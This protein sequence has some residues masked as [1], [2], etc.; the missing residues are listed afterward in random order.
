MAT[1]DP[2]DY[3]AATN[4]V[5]ASSLAEVVA[6]GVALLDERSPDWWRVISLNR[7]AMYHCQDCLLGQIWGNYDEGTRALG[8]I[9]GRAYGF[10]ISGG[11]LPYTALADLWRREIRRRIEA[12]P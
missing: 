5:L 1:T 6:K 4:P 11:S 2:F 7:L 8:N 10:N 3:L 9:S 12:T